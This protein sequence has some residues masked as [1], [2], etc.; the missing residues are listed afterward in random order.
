MSSPQALNLSPAERN[1]FAHL[2]AM[3]DP[4]NSGMV[5]G[6]AAVKFFEG[7]KLPTLT[8]GQI[9]SIA[10]SANNG[11]LTPNSFSVA[12][13]LI[14]RAQ[15]G[16]SVNDQ[17][18][19]QPG[20]PP[21]YSGLGL[22]ADRTAPTITNEDKARFTRIFTMVG[23]TN[24]VLSSDQAKDVFLKSKLP[25]AKLGEIWNLADTKQRGVLD[26]TDF[27]IGMHYIQGT[28]NGTIPTLP[29]VLP[30]GLYEAASESAP[31]PAANATPVPPPATT[32]MQ[33][34]RTGTDPYSAPMRSS[35]L[36][37]PTTPGL[38]A[39]P[40][41][42]AAPA[43]APS[44]PT[45]DWT[46]SPTDKA[47]YDGFF[48]SLDNQHAGYVDGGV[49]VPFFLQSGLDEAT[50][51]HVWDLADIT[52]DGTLNRDEF[53]VAMHLINEKMTGKA[54]PEHLPPALLPP[55]MRT[56]T[57]PAAG[58]TKPTETQRE[59]F[60]LLDTDVPPT[61][62]A[63]E[64]T[65]AFG[66][67]AAPSMTPMQPESTGMRVGMPPMNAS[68]PAPTPSAPEPLSRSAPADPFQAFDDEFEAPV[69]VARVDPK[70]DETL[71]ALS[72]TSKGIDEMKERQATATKTLGEQQTTLAEL[73]AQLARAKSEHAEQETAVAAVEQK[74]QAQESE[75]EALRQSVIREESEVSALKTQRTELEQKL[76]QDRDVAF[77]LKR[78]LSQLQLETEKMRADYARLEEEARAQ[79]ASISATRS[80]LTSA[81]DEQ[82]AL[83]PTSMPASNRF[84]PFS[85]MTGSAEE[86]QDRAAFDSQYGFDAFA[87]A[88]AGAATA[89][90]GGAAAL[91]ADDD[92][93]EPEKPE[94]A[95]AVPYSG[96][97]PLYD[98]VEPLARDVSEV[99]VPGEFPG[100]AT[101]DAT[102][103]IEREMQG[104]ALTRDLSG[105]PLPTEDEPTTVPPVPEAAQPPPSVVDEPVV[106]STAS[107]VAIPPSSEP[108][109]PATTQVDDF[110]MAFSRMGLAHV[111][112]TSTPRAG[113]T[114]NVRADSLDQNFGTSVPAR[115]ELPS[116]VP[117]AAKPLMVDVAP[118]TQ[119]TPAL[120][121]YLQTSSTKATPTVSSPTSSTPVPLALRAGAPTSTPA[122]GSTSSTSTP[123]S[124]GPISPPPTQTPSVPVSMPIRAPADQASPRDGFD[125][126]FDPRSRGPGAT[127]AA[128]TERPPSPPLPG[129]IGP[130]RQLCQMGFSRSAVVRALERSHYRTERALERLL[131]AA[132]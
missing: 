62:S 15:R 56:Q 127:G 99:S 114:D 68:A 51:A 93:D 60:S 115:E 124:G 20:A 27:I 77:E 120:P 53:A 38:G 30:P 67:P 98:G 94:E 129:D 1:S 41:R 132:K 130:V 74:V 72:S 5:T 100:A 123:A 29:S 73:E 64:K 37:S 14:A 52:Q 104:Q 92:A 42:S 75:I 34:Q 95:E 55:S 66:A 31:A 6:D 2:Y 65:S 54:L 103:G 32:P 112:H 80:Q 110:D 18:V 61:M 21:L 83:Q 8:L 71:A 12:L 28:M 106:S 19:Q 113:A 59:L 39:A 128:S 87:A 23:P 126:Q 90:A 47:R 84:N 117:G 3:A 57:L 96:R 63:S 10:D 44:M 45:S 35:S 131:S 16:E 109:T 40:P 49:V 121:S 105:K 33:P 7:F 125:D 25:I 91:E 88:G 82:A 101:D 50:L 108:A 4:T 26:L 89:G 36:M 48:D 107:V 69:P 81:K 85:M 70:H 9:W 102:A 17:A 79:Q 111:V 76:L 24:G 46:I 43:A 13:R 22:A 119:G 118:T 122:L 97:E 86:A 58:T 78:E 116:S 11:F